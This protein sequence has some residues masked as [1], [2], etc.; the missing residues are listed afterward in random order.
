MSDSMPGAFVPLGQ[1][2]TDKADAYQKVAHYKREW[3]FSPSVPSFELWCAATAYD[4]KAIPSGGEKFQ[5]LMH[6]LLTQ[7]VNDRA[8]ASTDKIEHWIADGWDEEPKYA[9][10]HWKLAQQGRYKAKGLTPA[11]AD[12][13]VPKS[14]A[15]STVPGMY[16]GMLSGA[17]SGFESG[18][19]WMKVVKGLMKS[20]DYDKGT[21]YKPTKAFTAANTFTPNSKLQWYVTSGLGLV[22]EKRAPFDSKQR[23]D[24]GENLSRMFAAKGT[25]GAAGEKQ[26]EGCPS[27]GVRIAAFYG[28]YYYPGCHDDA[29]QW[30]VSTEAHG[31][32]YAIRMRMPN[33][34]Y[35]VEGGMLVVQEPSNQGGVF[36]GS[37]G[38][39]VPQVKPSTMYDQIARLNMRKVTYNFGGKEVR[40]A[41]IVTMVSPWAGKLV[42]DAPNGDGLMW[43]DLHKSVYSDDI[44][45]WHNYL[46][47]RMSRREDHGD[48]Q[49][50]GLAFGWAIPQAVYLYPHYPTK[51]LNGT[52][53]ATPEF[54]PMPAWKGK[55]AAERKT[56]RL[57]LNRWQ[58][59]LPFVAYLEMPPLDSQKFALDHETP[60]VASL[61][62]LEARLT[63]G[64]EPTPVKKAAAKKKPPPASTY[65]PPPAQPAQDAGAQATDEQQ[66]ADELAEAQDVVEVGVDEDR[67]TRGAVL[68]ER[69]DDLKEDSMNPNGLDDRD[70]KGKSI[71]AELKKRL[72]PGSARREV[73]TNGNAHFFSLRFS[74]W[75][76]EDVYNPNQHKF[77]YEPAPDVEEYRKLYG[78]V[79]NLLLRNTS[80]MVFDRNEPVS[81]VFG[82]PR[83]IDGERILDMEIDA[84]NRAEYNLSDEDKAMFERNLQRIVA[85]YHGDGELGSKSSGA[86]I[87]AADKRKG[88]LNGIWTVATKCTDKCYIYYEGKRGD[89]REQILPPVFKKAPPKFT[90]VRGDRPNAKEYGSVKS[91]RSDMTV[92]EWLQTPWH[93]E[94]LPYQPMHSLFRDGETYS[95]GCTRCSRPFYEHEFLYH[96][97]YRHGVQNDEL[98]YTRHWP[99]NH[100]RADRELVDIDGKKKK[101]PADDKRFAPLPFH[102]ESFWSKPQR[103]VPVAEHA[104]PLDEDLDDELDADRGFHNWPLK[105][106]LLGW[107]DEKTKYGTYENH[108]WGPP[109]ANRAKT[110]PL[111]LEWKRR[112]DRNPP[113]K[114][115]KNLHEKGVWWLFREYINHVFVPDH[116]YDELVQ[117]V[118]RNANS[119]VAYGMRGYQLQR[120]VKYGN[121]CRDCAATLDLAPGLYQRTG[122]VV[123]DRGIADGVVM[124]EAERRIETYWLRFRNEPLYHKGK[125]IGTFDP[126]FI[127]IETGK[128][129]RFSGMRGGN[130]R[131]ASSGKQNSREKVIKELGLKQREAKRLME[132]SRQAAYERIF[133]D[134]ELTVEQMVEAHLHAVE[135]YTRRTNCNFTVEGRKLTKFATAAEVHVQPSLNPQKEDLAKI[136]QEFKRLI[137]WLD[138]DGDDTLTV[139]RSEWVRP[140]RDTLRQVHYALA[141]GHAYTPDP[142]TVRT[143]FDPHVTREEW[144]SVKKGG[145]ENCL[146]TKTLQKPSK[147]QK[148]GTTV[149]APKDAY[150]E[151]TYY[152]TIGGAHKGQWKG[153]LY[154]K[155]EAY[156]VRKLQ[157]TRVFITY[158]LHRRIKSEETA[159]L[160]MET[161]ADAVRALFGNDEYMCELLL[162][163]MRLVNTGKADTISQYRY[164]PITGARKEDTLFY[165]DTTGNSY[166]YDTYETHVNQVSVDAGCEIGPTYQM[167]HFH[168]L[169][170]I[171]HWSYVQVDTMRM[172]AMLE[173]MFKGTGRWSSDHSY[174]LLD[175]GGFPFYTDNENPYVDIRLFPSDNWAEVIAAYVRKTATPGI[176]ESLR[177]RTGV[178]DSNARNA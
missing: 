155:A 166:L 85:I 5:T 30:T 88:M 132:M 129:K 41:A 70:D 43:G 56:S 103:D 3:P 24:G 145:Y 163:G 92:L 18:A 14:Y 48:D 116:D 32:R 178:S 175:E 108:K 71:Y 95:M 13:Y 49:D 1:R 107:V 19:D 117:G 122:R 160:V 165:G 75:A 29:L 55:T 44:D 149:T 77:N 164:E 9:G 159:R 127:L 64:A 45:T 152:A 101:V 124:A 22:Q 2:R 37:D 114:Q 148:A 84:C 157:Q 106:F 120:S 158:S 38:F 96:W 76:P 135:A 8:K 176:M 170:T 110:G 60:R 177:T 81:Q 102:H 99:H 89:G 153:D 161:M 174:V 94:Y 42:A 171:D 20:S 150:V 40:P 52:S 80:Q 109:K 162:F 172:K 112:M 34:A 131:D 140:M 46:G 105:L 26:S 79:G 50:G 83:E 98:M 97:M 130:E 154:R 74:P 134:S 4:H 11:G 61:E 58:E 78:N 91:V 73:D 128:D 51:L 173:Q 57:A 67:T 126:W 72:P 125:R 169:V 47:E 156:Q 167:P 111:S 25:G 35:K 63:S 147:V 23:C 121:V 66:N 136:S 86:R 113:P 31:K 100:W 17:K 115:V 36:A 142:K 7:H 137:K 133:A 65:K 168:A 27:A 21:S 59:K 12:A 119:S 93:Y 10:S 69:G 6:A 82:T 62:A 151:H 90:L 139:D 138:S 15:Q 143:T 16:M 28:L 104:A 54:Q 123:V 118:V 53:G 68:D 144:R 39:F 141:Q 87:S 33:P 146:V